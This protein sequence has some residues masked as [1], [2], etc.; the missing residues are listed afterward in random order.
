MC[1]LSKK[2]SIL[3]YENQTLLSMETFLSQ[4]LRLL[5]HANCTLYIEH[6]F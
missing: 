3:Y 4:T 1:V 5:I 6:N 2:L